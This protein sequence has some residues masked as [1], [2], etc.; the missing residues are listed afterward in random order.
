[1]VD[2]IY[3]ENREFFKRT[4]KF[5]YFIVGVRLRFNGD[6]FF[7][8][9]D[10]FGTIIDFFGKTILTSLVRSDYVFSGVV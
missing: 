10:F 9:G 5:S 8:K 3:V 7:S 1:V 6:N 2:Q 4:C